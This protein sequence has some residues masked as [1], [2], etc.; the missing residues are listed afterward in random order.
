MPRRKIGLGV[1]GF[2]DLLFKLAVAYDS[3]EALRIANRVGSFIR[4]AGWAASERLAEE[5]GTFPSWKGSIWDREQG[6]RPM[7]NAHVTTIAPTGTISIIAGCSSGIEP[8]FSLAFTRQVL[9]GKKLVEVNPVFAAALRDH[10]KD[11]NEAQRIMSNMRPRTGRFRMS[12]YC[13]KS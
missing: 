12:P 6:G 7:R 13:P 1:M 2:A 8:L 3:E 9:G 10:I 4:E 5:R 11:E